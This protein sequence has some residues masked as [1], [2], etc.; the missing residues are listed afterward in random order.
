M[1][2]RGRS[3]EFDEEGMCGTQKLV[4]TGDLTLLMGNLQ[5][6]FPGA[7]FRSEAIGTATNLLKLLH[8][9]NTPDLSSRVSTKQVSDHFGR[10]WRE[11]SG[12]ITA[13]RDFETSLSNA[14]W[15]YVSKRGAAGA[16]FERMASVLQ[17]DDEL[18]GHREHLVEL[19]KAHTHRQHLVELIKAFAANGGLT[20]AE[21]EPPR[22]G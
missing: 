21:E 8:Y 22:T 12:D 11:I 5:R 17:T 7:K 10:R 19:I 9:L 1:A 3:R 14:G 15:G 6:I 16:Y 20:A 13:H 4:V 18:G 2:L